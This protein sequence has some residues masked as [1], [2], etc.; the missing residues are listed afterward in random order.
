M[1]ASAVPVPCADKPCFPGDVLSDLE[2]FE[3]VVLGPGVVQE[4]TH[5]VATR[6]GIS[7]WDAARSLLWV[8]TSLKRYWPALN[9]HV[10]GIV[11]DKGAEDYKLEIGAAVK[12]MLPVLAFDG[13]T[14]RNRPHLAVGTLVY[15]RVVL[16][17]KDMEPE[18]SCAAPPGVN[19]RD[20]VTKE[21]V[22]GELT[23]GHVFDCPSSVCRQLM[24]TDCPLL[25]AIG[26]VAPFEI[27]VGL[28]GR[29]WLDSKAETTVVL[30][31]QAIRMSPRHAP[32][33][34]FRMVQ[35][36]SHRFDT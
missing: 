17:N 23:G 9:D 15:A 21:S 25:E 34:H 36:L 29:V 8:E 35:Q 28:N 13:A 19:A 5:L 3:Q 18:V 31:Q 27:A 16:A 11:T 1:A 26:S 10:I 2:A 32:Q 12:A 7:R 6:V 30:A 4:D 24:S 20:W 33:D 22:F 14:K